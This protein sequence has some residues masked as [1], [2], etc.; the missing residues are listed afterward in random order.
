M[1]SS[2]GTRVGEYAAF[3]QN[4][5]AL[6]R[7]MLLLCPSLDG[8]LHSNR[9]MSAPRRKEPGTTFQPKQLGFQW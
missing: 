2:F 4:E 5:T 8:R 7:D 6:T 1:E 9:D 3:S